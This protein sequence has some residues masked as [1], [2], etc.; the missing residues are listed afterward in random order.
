MRMNSLSIDLTIKLPLHWLASSMQGL[1][2]SQTIQAGAD[3]VCRLEEE[4]TG[5]SRGVGRVWSKPHG[6]KRASDSAAQCLCDVRC[7]RYCDV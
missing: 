3:R 7:E 2:Q 5:C 6:L 4:R 1:K